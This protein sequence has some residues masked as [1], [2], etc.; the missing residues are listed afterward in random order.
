MKDLLVK[1]A[2]LLFPL[3]LFSQEHDL[4][5]SDAI[6][7]NFKKYS[8]E[9]NLAYKNKDFKRGKFLFDSLVKGQLVGTK[10]DNYSFKKIQGGK[11][12][13]EAS[14]KPIFLLTYASWCVP[15]KGEIP[16]LN[17]LAQKYSNDVKFVVLFWDKKHNVKKVA[18]KFNSHIT[19]CFAH[20]TY[21]ND[22][23][24]ISSIK[25]TLG[26]PTCFYLDEDLKI[27]DIKRG[28]ENSS[29]SVAY[30]KAYTQNY[31]TFRDGLST[32]LISKNISKE[33]L[34]TN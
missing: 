1:I 28:G 7:I 30:M 12:N 24:A 32:I 23:S 2:L 20:E 26:F 33:R 29:P 14:K 25:H 5:F 13:L 9:S 21:K 16:A 22:A 34:A 11:L 31:N 18:K 27:V 3:F 6:K 4:F 8:S 17:K 15:S 10:F 19:V